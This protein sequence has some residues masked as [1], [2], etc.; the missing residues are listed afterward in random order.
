[1]NSASASPFIDSSPLDEEYVLDAH[2]STS[3]LV[4][5]SVE[6]KAGTIVRKEMSDFALELARWLAWSSDDQK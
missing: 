4:A 3:A 1:M 5:N 6:P 2:G